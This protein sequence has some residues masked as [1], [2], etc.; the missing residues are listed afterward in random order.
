[1]EGLGFAVVVGDLAGAGVVVPIGAVAEFEAVDVA[2]A[3]GVGGRG[4]ATVGHPAG[5]DA[6]EDAVGKFLEE[7]ADFFLVGWR[8]RLRVRAETSMW[9]FGYRARRS[10]MPSRS[11]S[12]LPRWAPT[13]TSVGCFFMMLSRAAMIAALAGVAGLA[14]EV[15]LGVL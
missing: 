4:V 9:K 11:C 8:V 13:T 2:A 5:V 15:P 6:V 1:M 14:V 12:R 10:A 3:L 7:G